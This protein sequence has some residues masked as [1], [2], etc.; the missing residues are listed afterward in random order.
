MGKFTRLIYVAAVFLINLGGLQAADLK[1]GFLGIKWETN[2]S[3]LPD[4]VQVTQKYDIKYYGNPSKSYTLFG[5]D[6][7]YITYAFY[8]DKFFAAY[9][10]V[11]SIDVFEKLKQHLTQKYGSPRTTLK[12]NEGQTIYIWKHADTKIKLKLYENEGKM[13]LGFYYAPLAAK[14]NKT[15]REEFPP[16]RKPVFPLDERRLREAME[17]MGF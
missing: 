7:P 1:D 3:E 15:Q 5:V 9:V 14:V 13:K 17:V 16:P 2:I 10:D 8:A 12:F 4:F 11:A 6:V